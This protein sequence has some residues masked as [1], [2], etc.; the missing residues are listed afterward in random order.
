MMNQ[1]NKWVY[2]VNNDD[3]T[4]IYLDLMDNLRNNLSQTRDDEKGK[5]NS[6]TCLRFLQHKS[7]F[8]S[9]FLFTFF[10]Q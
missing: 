7:L 6:R 1:N 9:S 8:C 4:L 3:I 5:Q 10:L 2:S